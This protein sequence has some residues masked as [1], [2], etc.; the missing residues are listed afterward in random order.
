VKIAGRA[1]SPT[2]SLADQNRLFQAFLDARDEGNDAAAVRALDEL[3][4]RFPDTPLADQARLARFRA[5]QRLGG[6]RP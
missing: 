6:K 3:L 1:P 5:L 2:P 4:A